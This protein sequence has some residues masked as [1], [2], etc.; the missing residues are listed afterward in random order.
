MIDIP[1]TAF[2]RVLIQCDRARDNY[3]IEPG[4][5]LQVTI[6]SLAIARGCGL[7][8]RLLIDFLH[9]ADLLY[10]FGILYCIT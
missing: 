6:P 8:T 4:I 3:A 1:R 7:G 5:C 9:V 2:L 10:H